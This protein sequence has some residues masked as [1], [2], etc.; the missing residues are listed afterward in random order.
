MSAVVSG[1]RSKAKRIAAWRSQLGARAFR[2]FGLRRC[3]TLWRNCR[4]LKEIKGDCGPILQNAIEAACNNDFHRFYHLASSLSAIKQ[5]RD[6]QY[7]DTYQYI[8]GIEDVDTKVTWLTSGTCEIFDISNPVRPR[9]LGV[10]H[11]GPSM[12]FRVSLA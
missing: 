12:N 9:R 7:G 5:T 11:S 3:A 8:R 2:T 4:K 10:K 6:T 1:K